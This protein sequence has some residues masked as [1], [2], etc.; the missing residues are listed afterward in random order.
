[1]NDASETQSMATSAS[2]FI[3]YR[4]TSRNVFLNVNENN[5]N[6]RT[7]LVPVSNELNDERFR[8]TTQSG[9]NRNRG[10]LTAR[11][12][13]EGDEELHN[14]Q[15]ADPAFLSNGFSVAGNPQNTNIARYKIIRDG[16]SIGDRRLL[17]Q[18]STTYKNIEYLFFFFAIIL[19]LCI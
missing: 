7:L 17:D 19:T 11:T 12:E 2:R 16:S 10:G 1:M 8:I 6:D 3:N 15:A 4:V 9:F 18:E 5:E 13:G 14:A